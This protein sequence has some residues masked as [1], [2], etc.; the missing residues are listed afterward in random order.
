MTPPRY[1]VLVVMPHY[2]PGRL[3]GGPV[4]TLNNMVGRLTP[5]KFLIATLDHD[6]DGTPYASLPHE[7]PIPVDRADVLYFSRQRFTPAN[8]REVLETHRIPVLYLN[9]FFSTITIR[10]LL[11]HRVRPFEAKVVVAPRGEFSPGAYALKRAKK[12]AF[13]RLFRGLGLARKVTFQASSA[14]EADEIRAKLGAVAIHVAPDVPALLDDLPERADTAEVA[15]VFLS[16]L[17]PKKNLAYAIERVCTLDVP[18]V[19]DIYGPLED[20]AYW[21]TCQALIERAPGH[22]RIRYCGLVDHADVR[23]TFGAYD[24][25]LFPTL[26]ENYGHVIYEALSAGC[27]VILSDQTPWQDFAQHGVGWVLPLEQSV[28]F[29]RALRSVLAETPQERQ[30]S[31]EQ[32][33]TYARRIADAPEVLS[34]NLVLL[35]R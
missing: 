13:V 9:S 17:V 14:M 6:L 19:L 30:Q 4:T 33:W 27:R 31:R 28:S 21:Q 16:R 3:A 26:G 20:A 34:A 24:A 29:E 35:K 23:Q 10:S 7:L 11:T 15:F 5:I 18:C 2:L 8:L 12:E 32:C 25:F 22:V 1:D